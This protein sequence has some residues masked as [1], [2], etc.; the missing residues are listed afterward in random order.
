MKEHPILKAQGCFRAG[1]PRPWA[2]KGG[3]KAAQQRYRELHKEEIKER[4]RVAYRKNPEKHAAMSR[5]WRKANPEKWKGLMRE[6]NRRVR[7]RL[8]RE[9][10]VAYGNKC[11]CCGEA[12]PTFLELDH[13]HNDGAKDRQNGNGWG[14]KLLGRLKKMGW[15]TDSYQ[16]LCSNCNQG[17]QR[18]GGICPHKTKNL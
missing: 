5:A 3:V 6:S 18:N 11:T 14:V 8:R 15:P 4:K 7:K 9:M 10:I 13:I 2:Y 16:L 17:K 12:E 1:I